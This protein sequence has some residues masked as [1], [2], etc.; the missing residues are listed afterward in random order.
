MTG[1]EPG[2]S[3]GYWDAFY[4]GKGEKELKAAMGLA[5][6][7]LTL[8]FTESRTEQVFSCPVMALMALDGVWIL[9][10]LSL[11]A[12]SHG[13]LHFLHFPTIVLSLLGANTGPSPPT[14]SLP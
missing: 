14:T 9:T 13:D 12:L 5:R 7:A 11:P 8:P 10:L 2:M 6:P 4:R 1:Y 3:C